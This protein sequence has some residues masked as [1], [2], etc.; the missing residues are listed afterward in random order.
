MKQLKLLDY[1]IIAVV[2]AVLIIGA[3][4][5]LGKNKFSKSPVEAT[6]KIAFQVMLK[7]VSLTDS[8]MPFKIGEESFITIRNVPYT[9]LQ[10]IDVAYQ[11]KKMVLPINNPQQ[12][13]VVI[14]DYSMP[15]QFDFIVTLIDDAKITKDGAVV[16][17]NKIKIG[18]PIVLEGFNYRIG[19]TISNVQILEDKQVEEINKF[20]TQAKL[21]SKMDDALQSKAQNAPKEEAKPEKQVEKSA[22]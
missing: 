16:G 6:K 4:A 5:Y 15:Y 11:A 10:I 9:K 12:P 2:I 7:S 20:V 21:Q 17:G 22:E 14:D 18:L 3:L 8:K 19:G 1:I 13:F